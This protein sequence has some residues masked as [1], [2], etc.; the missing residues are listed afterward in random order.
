MKAADVRSTCILFAAAVAILIGCGDNGPG[1][2]DTAGDVTPDVPVDVNEDAGTAEPTVVVENF[3][4][5]YGYASTMGDLPGEILTGDPRRAARGPGEPPWAGNYALA[6]GSLA[7]I[8]LD[9]SMGCFPNRD[10][11]LMAVATTPAEG[12]PG[13]VMTVVGFDGSMQPSVLLAEPL[14]RVRQAVFSGSR[15]Y[16][17]LFSEQPCESPLGTAKTCYVFKV[18]DFSGNG[19]YEALRLFDFPRPEQLDSSLYSGRF[20]M[21]ADGSTIIIQNL[22]KESVAIWLYDV[23]GG[24]RQ[25]GP[26]FCQA[27]DLE[28]RCAYSSDNPSKTDDDPVALTADGKSLVYVHV[29]DGREFRL[30]RMSTS[31]GSMAFTTLVRVPGRYAQNAC[32]NL[33]GGPW[34]YTAIQQPVLISQDGTEV[35]FTASSTC[36]ASVGKVWTNILAV[37]IDDIG[38]VVTDTDFFRKV[39]DFPAK[40]VPGCISVMA[41]TMSL[42]PSGRYLAFVGSASLDSSGQPITTASPQHF[43][44]QEAYVTATDGLS[45][46]IQIS[47]N[48]NY[49]AVSTMCSTV[50][51]WFAAFTDPPEPEE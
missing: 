9:C 12:V 30:V 11:T 25:V 20:R 47:G 6:A 4:V 8:G 5:L 2:A 22:E 18:I 46:P 37:K 38:N 39:T 41:D 14:T 1:P 26:K 13:Q 29:E 21:G 15:L 31:D 19:P 17:S 24:L 27:R 7:S 43:I 42:S 45:A 32:Y 40:P 49:R 51:P 44:D 28:D 48:L 33:G 34:V 3:R 35:I 10:L 16:V 36:D 23:N 50:D